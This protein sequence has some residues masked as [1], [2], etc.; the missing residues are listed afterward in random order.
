MRAELWNRIKETVGRAL[1]L[2]EGEREAFVREAA[3]GDA[4]LEREALALLAPDDDESTWIDDSPLLHLF[5]VPGGRF[6]SYE[7]GEAIGAGG[8]GAVFRARDDLGRTVAL[9]VLRWFDRVEGRSNEQFQREFEALRRVNHEGVVS[10]LDGGTISGQ[11]YLAMEFVDGPS[12]RRIVDD[13]RNGAFHDVLDLREPR[14]A[15][16]AIVELLDALDHV[17]GLGIVHRDVKPENILLTREGRVRL[18]D[19][20]IARDVEWAT[21][22]RTGHAIGSVHYMSPEQARRVRQAPDPRSDI[23]SVGSVFYEL[24]TLARA[25]DGDDPLT[26]LERIL[27]DDPAPIEH[28]APKVP[29]LLA[30]AC[31]AALAK[32][33][34]HRYGSAR[35]FATA[36][37]AILDG[38]R[39]RLPCVPLAHRVQRRVER[40]PR[41]SAALGSFVLA[42]LM[43][44]PFVMDRGAFAAAETADAH[45]RSGVAAV[46]IPAVEERD[47]TTIEIRVF[48]QSPFRWRRL[49]EP[50][51]AP[52]QAT[53]YHVEPGLVWGLVRTSRGP[54]EFVRVLAAGESLVVPRLG[55]SDAAPP[56]DMVP[57]AARRHTVHV[58]GPQEQGEF[59][60]S[61]QDFWIDRQ[62]VTNAQFLAFLHATGRADVLRQPQWNATE[63]RARRADWDRLPATSMNWPL[64]EEYAEWCGK[65]LP[66]LPEAQVAILAVLEAEGVDVASL[67]D[68]EIS[69]T[70]AVGGTTAPASSD[71]YLQHAKPVDDRPGAVHALGNVWLMTATSAP[72]LQNGRFWCDPNRY[73]AVG[74]SYATAAQQVR[75]GRDRSFCA[76]TRMH[77]LGAADH[78]FRCVRVADR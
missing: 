47:G 40:Y 48:D 63:M 71:S 68:A 15:A 36:L 7:V 50:V 53:E 74:Y 78:G 24:L 73:V 59:E 67:T 21:L 64:A 22:T 76:L 43:F 3:A 75:D 55:R 65:R 58:V 57:I 70:F 4:E 20:G 56:D 51:P 11:L 25:F 16:R 39:V 29:R 34:T 32:D 42:A 54:A 9:K 28:R 19:F 66:T 49:H 33:R 31:R 77:A 13:A 44:L 72:E 35:E 45:R 38:D 23:F 10:V 8:S 37:R 61:V 26:V 52:F 62:P 69:A 5:P 12:L 2:E 18:V 17:H 46:V 30:D 60:A 41:A 27:H 6:G 1:E 14:N